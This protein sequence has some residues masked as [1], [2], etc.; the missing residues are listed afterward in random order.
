MEDAMI[1]QVWLQ[2]I[3]QVVQFAG[4]LLLAWEWF[5]ARRQDLAE[6]AIAAD[7][8]RREEGIAG[9]QRVQPGNPQ[10]QRHFEVT[11]DMQ[12]RMTAAR[13]Y[14]TRA[15]YGGLRAWAVAMSLVLVAIGFVTQLLGSWPGC[16]RLIGIVPMG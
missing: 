4:V 16:C 11:L 5:A 13:V 1:G 12:R 8:A 7:Q 10:M 14:E 6:H 15:H 9:L 3:G 2:V